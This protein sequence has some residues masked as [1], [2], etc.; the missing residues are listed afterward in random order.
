MA[1]GPAKKIVDF[2]RWRKRPWVKPE[3]SR[4][5]RWTF[6]EVHSSSLSNARVVL[7]VKPFSEDA[8][9]PILP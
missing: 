5:V 2:S 7:L 8:K 9:G 6:L 4:L 3:F 1:T